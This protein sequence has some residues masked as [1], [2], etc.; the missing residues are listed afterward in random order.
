[1]TTNNQQ[2]SLELLLA[3]FEVATSL[4]VDTHEDN[5]DWLGGAVCKVLA[6]DYETLDDMVIALED[7]IKDLKSFKMHLDLYRKGATSKSH[8]NEIEKIQRE[9]TQSASA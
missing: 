6:N 9:L 3:I 5:G 2:V 8:M 7:Y 1:M 4:P